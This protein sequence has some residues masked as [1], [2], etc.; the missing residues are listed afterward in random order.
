MN[1]SFTLSFYSIVV[2]VELFLLMQRILFLLGFVW[3][4]LRELIKKHS[5]KK[6]GTNSYTYQTKLDPL[7]MPSKYKLKFE[8]F[9]SVFRTWEGMKVS[10]MALVHYFCQNQ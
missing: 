7:P 8:L 9:M 5:E 3:F 2:H 10:R 6:K 4:D 1:Q